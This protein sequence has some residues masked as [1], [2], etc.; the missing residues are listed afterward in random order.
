[1]RNPNGFGGVAKL[2]G[3]RRNPYRARVTMGWELTPTNE[4]RQIYHTLGYYAT[5]K[6]ALL[7]LAEY[8]RNPYDLATRN[9]TFDYCFNAWTEKHRAKHPVAASGF[10]S[11]YRLCDPIKE[12]P[13]ID[14]RLK[15][16]QEIMDSVSDRSIS[17][18]D[19]LKT[20]FLKTFRF[21]MENDIVQKNYAQYVTITKTPPKQDIKNK[22]FTT[23]Q[24]QA[25][26]DKKDT[27]LPFPVQRLSYVDVRPAD[28]ILVLLYTGVRIGELLSIKCSDIDLSARTIH[29]RGTKTKSADRIVPIHKN[30]I[31]YIQN[32]LANNREYLFETPAGNP[33]NPKQYASYI[34]T[35]FMKLIGATHTPHATRHTF[36]SL[37]DKCGITA[38]SVVLK[39]IVGHANSSI[40]EHYTHKELDELLSAIDRF[41][42]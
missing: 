24:I 31:P 23:E 17:L 39:R 9:A 7:A 36:I 29:V 27:L 25:I 18:Q 13:M 41:T 35:P 37:M 16:L 5:R 30:I 10:Q 42:L 28:S 26:L 14:I 21:A 11:L 2:P 19:K 15:H 32:S 1:M 20:I 3:K 12:L 34:F 40:T 22:F 8:N 6:E 38:D 33:Y 4:P